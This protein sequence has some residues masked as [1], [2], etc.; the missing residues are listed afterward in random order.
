MQTGKGYIRDV[1]IVRCDR[2]EDFLGC[3]EAAVEKHGIKNGLLLTGYGTLEKSTVQ[4]V[5]STGFPVQ[6]HF[7]HEEQALEVLSLDGLVADGKIY[8]HIV[9]SDTHQAWGGHLESGC[10][11]LYLC[12]AVIGILE[13]VA[14]S[15]QV[16]PQGLKL[17]EIE[18][19]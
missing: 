10:R 12:E 3:L 8:A 11:V 16:S 9:L 15:R 7:E 4:M 14:L 2:S 18:E 19:V 1:V 6:E 17:L 13:D 5:T